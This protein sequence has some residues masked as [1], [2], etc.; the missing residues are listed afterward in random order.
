M[1]YNVKLQETQCT[2][3]VVFMNRDDA[4]DGYDLFR[5]H[6]IELGRGD[7]WV[8][9]SADESC[10]QAGV[11]VDTIVESDIADYCSIA[12]GLPEDPVDPVQGEALDLEFSGAGAIPDNDPAGLSL[13]ASTQDERLITEAFV[14]VDI[15]HSWRGDLSITLVHPDGKREVIQEANPGDSEDNLNIRLQSAELVGKSAAGA[16][17]LIVVD[18][19]A[20]DT[21]SVVKA[22]LELKVAE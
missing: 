12:S 2:A 15:T 13:S 3:P 16:Y 18:N 1:D 11:A 5:Q 14:F 7:Q 20:S 10:P 9:W 19:A 22:V 8:A 21:G 17:E 4:G 6:A